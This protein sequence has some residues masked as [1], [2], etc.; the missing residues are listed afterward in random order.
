MRQVS[1][2]IRCYAMLALTAA[3]LAW[4]PA[5][6]GDTPSTASLIAEVRRAFTMEGKPIP[7][8]IFRDFEDGNLA[9]S[10]PI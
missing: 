5:L 2:N 3:S 8:E 10:G 9:D 7:P 4:S 1:W 6:A